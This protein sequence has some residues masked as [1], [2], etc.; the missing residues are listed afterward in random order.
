MGKIYFK[1][2]Y[3]CKEEDEK[4]VVIRLP[5]QIKR[6]VEG[7][8]GLLTTSLLPWR[9]SYYFSVDNVEVQKK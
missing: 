8:E 9:K 7:M 5:K 4:E 3:T 6:V 1:V 2:E